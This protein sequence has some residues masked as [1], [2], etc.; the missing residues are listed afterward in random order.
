MNTAGMH[1]VQGT[2]MKQY[3]NHM[4]PRIYLSRAVC[5]FQ[6]FS[7]WLPA[8]SNCRPFEIC[9]ESTLRTCILYK[10]KPNSGLIVV[11][12]VGSVDLSVS[13]WEQ[14]DRAAGLLLNTYKTLNCLLH[15]KYH[16]IASILGVQQAV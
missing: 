12:L 2:E 1:D 5:I 4:K 14:T 16:S 11:R 15:C 10:I 3:F 9:R 13:L 8:R 6:M 7:F